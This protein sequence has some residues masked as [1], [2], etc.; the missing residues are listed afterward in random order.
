[1]Q[2]LEE[3]N[4][5]TTGN[6]DSRAEQGREAVGVVSIRWVQLFGYTFRGVAAS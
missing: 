6:Y 4:E 3:E 5:H 1:M 2:E